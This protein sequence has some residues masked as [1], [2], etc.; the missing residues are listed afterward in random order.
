[1]RKRETIDKIKIL[2]YPLILKNLK[3]VK[4]VVIR[5]PKLRY[6]HL[7]LNFSG[8][9]NYDHP[10]PTLL[11]ICPC[12]SGSVNKCEH[13]GKQTL[14]GNSLFSQ[15]TTSTLKPLTTWCCHTNHLSPPKQSTSINTS[16]DVTSGQL[17]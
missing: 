4:R 17:V 10:P 16:L 14:R 9:T 1:M 2:S 11:Q 5:A 12:P 6:P 3:Q 7:T 15:V 8:P 13:E